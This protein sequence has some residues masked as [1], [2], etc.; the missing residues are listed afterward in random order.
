MLAHAIGLAALLGSLSMPALADAVREAECGRATAHATCRGFDALPSPDGGQPELS[1]QAPAQADDLE[2]A[3][4]KRAE[5]LA[6]TDYTRLGTCQGLVRDL[7]RWG[8]LDNLGTGIALGLINN[9]TRIA[10]RAKASGNQRLQRGSADFVVGFCTA[11]MHVHMAN[12]DGAKDVPGVVVPNQAVSAVL[13]SRTARLQSRDTSNP[14]R[15]RTHMGKLKDADV[16]D[17]VADVMLRLELD[18]AIE[19]GTSGTPRQDPG[20]SFGNGLCSAVLNAVMGALR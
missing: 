9:T 3:A 18:N 20:Q 2:R 19:Q 10:R 8:V 5:I 6:G 7:Y 15:C 1:A 12:R 14:D 16:I 13:Q 17:E 11:T 4:A